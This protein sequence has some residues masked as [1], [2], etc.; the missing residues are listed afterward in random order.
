MELRSLGKYRLVQQLDV[1]SEACQLYLV[2]HEDEPRDDRCSYV[3]KLLQPMRGATAAQAEARRGRFEHEI[4]LL[5][6]LNHTCIPTLHAA[7]EQDG[8]PYIVMDRVDGADL[9]TVLGHRRGRPRAISKE[10]AVYIMGQLTDALHHLHTLELVSEAGPE[11]LRARHRNLGPH[12]VMLSAAGDA[13]LGGFG[14]ASSTWLPAEHD[15]PSLG[16]LAYMAPERL[17]GAASE[18][19]DL[20]AMAVMLWEMLK[21]QRCLAAESDARTRENI[22]RFDIG[23]SSRRVSGLSP[24]LSEIVRRNLDRDPARRYTSAYQMLQRLAQSPEAQSAE[25]SRA[26]LAAL[27]SEVHASHT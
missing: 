2:R 22:G 7:G 17:E 21:G 24:K 6:A 9:A 23:Q 1:P 14:S 8:V 10:L 19:T 13:V 12:N 27:V 20:F 16:D 26:Q 18:R 3:A 15:D 25:V 5:Q 4:K 11:P